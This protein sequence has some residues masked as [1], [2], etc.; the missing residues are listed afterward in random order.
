MPDHFSMFDRYRQLLAQVRAS[1]SPE[2][3][4]EEA[5]SEFIAYIAYRPLSFW[6]TP[7]FMLAGFTADAVTALGFVVALAMPVAALGLGSNGFWAVAALG[8]AMQVL[9]CVD[10]NI[11]RAT[12]RFSPVGP[13]LDGL[14][15]LLF[16]ASYFIA[17][18]ALAAAM[19]VGWIGLHGREVGLGLAVLQLAQ[20]QMEDTFTDRFD[21]RVRWEPSLP[22]ALPRWDLKRIGKPLEQVVAFGGLCVAGAFGA[23]HLFLGVLAVYQVGLFALWLPRYVIAVRARSRQAS[24]TK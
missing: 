14:C 1:Y 11:A 15:T 10:G 16:W 13:M 18:G 9:D 8:V 2:K 12:R 5:D 19:P 21:E 24:S 23:M 7:C 4:R 22:A 6:I 20:R 17:V 3:A